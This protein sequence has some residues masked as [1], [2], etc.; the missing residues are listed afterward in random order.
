MCVPYSGIDL[1]IPETHR[2][3]LL[4]MWSDLSLRK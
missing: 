2:I 1:G 4:L 3:D